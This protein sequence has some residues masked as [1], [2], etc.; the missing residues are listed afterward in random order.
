LPIS[1]VYA[2]VG[3]NAIWTDTLLR[4]HQVFNLPSGLPGIGH[5]NYICELRQ[6]TQV[7]I[8]S[9]W[10]VGTK[11]ECKFRRL[12]AAPDVYFLEHE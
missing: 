3:K 10:V 4:Q 1:Q 11:D 2:A 5:V 9:L 12:L 8:G 7:V 6:D